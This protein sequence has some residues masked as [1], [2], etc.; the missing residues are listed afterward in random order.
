MKGEKKNGGGGQ[1]PNKAAQTSAL[2]CDL[3]SQNALTVHFRV[4][5]MIYVYYV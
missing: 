3:L 4:S 1:N 2:V 5:T